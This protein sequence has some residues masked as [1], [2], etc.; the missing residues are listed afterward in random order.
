[1][2]RRL[3]QR[4]QAVR[5][6]RSAPSRPS[7]T[8]ARRCCCTPRA[9]A[10]RPTSPPG[11]PTRRPSGWPR[12][13]ALA[14]VAA[15][16]EAGRAGDRLGDPG[17]R[18][19]RLH[20]GGR[21]ALALQAR[22]ARRGAARRRRARARIALA[23][24]VAAA[25]R[26]TL[27]ASRSCA[28]PSSRISAAYGAGGSAIGPAVAERLGVPFVDRAIPIGRGRAARRLRA[29][30]GATAT[31][32]SAP[33][34]P[35]RCSRSAR[36]A[37]CSAGRRPARRSP[38]TDEDFRE[39]T[40]QVAARARGR[41]GGRG[42]PRPRRRARA[43]PTHPA[44][45]ARAA[46]R[47]RWTRASRRRMRAGGR[48]TGRTAER[49]AAADRPRARGY[50]RHFYR[51]DARDPSHYHLV[52]D[53]T[54]LRSTPAR[55]LVGGGG[56]G[57]VAGPRLARPDLS[58]SA[59]RRCAPR[60][61]PRG[62][63]SRAL[64]A[65]R[66]ADRAAAAAAACARAGVADRR[67]ELARLAGLRRHRAAHRGALLDELADHLDLRRRR[68][69]SAA[70]PAAAGPGGRRARRGPCG[71]A[72]AARRRRRPAGR[73]RRRSVRRCARGRRSRPATRRV[74]RS[75]R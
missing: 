31:S 29:R 45:A 53:S 48:S 5:R 67:G 12:P 11:R 68:G 28:C 32:P 30:R 46:H 19:H 36:W 64:G 22:A 63:R 10:R 62:A 42:D 3:R 20:L 73:R 41:G 38:C 71:P 9:R 37:R 27:P 58:A 23:R 39:A 40:E 65:Q 8:A 25:P 47:A 2:T 21:R 50:V 51:A 74:R 35:A 34:S 15:A 13:P 24:L 14:R 33:G 18:R 75:P 44:R 60:R 57:A 72:G 1:M 59:R 61:G 6:A 52:L 69:A 4:A 26:G 55:A 16:A 66:H 54:A 49:L 7:R 70:G 43:A 56:A 17:P